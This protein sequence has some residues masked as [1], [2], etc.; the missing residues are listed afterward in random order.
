MPGCKFIVLE[1]SQFWKSPRFRPCLTLPCTVPARRAD[2]IR[3]GSICKIEPAENLLFTYGEPLGLPHALH[4]VG[5]C[6]NTC[7][8][9]PNHTF[10]RQD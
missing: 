5:F 4:I 6:V 7:M 10:Q 1:F 9:V 3:C 8:F 2:A